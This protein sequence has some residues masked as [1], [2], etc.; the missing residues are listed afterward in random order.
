MYYA[1]TIMQMAGFRSHSD[2]TSVAMVVA[3]TNMVFTGVAVKMIDRV[4]RRRMLIVTMGAMI[5]GLVALGSSFAALQGVTPKQ[6]T[7]E[8]YG[9]VCARCIIDERCEW[10]MTT[11]SCTLSILGGGT[12]SECPADQTDKPTSII[13]LLSLFAYVGSYALGLGYAPWVRA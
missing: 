8:M 13:L 12:V 11:D 6:D 3:M 9:S 10:S 4:G 2:S 1:A 7:C 5:V